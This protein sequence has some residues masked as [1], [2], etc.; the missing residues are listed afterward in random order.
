MS[1]VLAAVARYPFLVPFLLATLG[2]TTAWTVATRWLVE[3]IQPEHACNTWTNALATA[4]G[5]TLVFATSFAGVLATTP[6]FGV[7]GEAQA[8]GLVAAVVLALGAGL[9]RRFR[10]RADDVLSAAPVIGTVGSAF[11]A[12]LFL[13]GAG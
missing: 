2:A 11:G 9:M 12:V 13:V 1:P 4:G 5:T 6:R 7:L 3:A 10:M 8:L